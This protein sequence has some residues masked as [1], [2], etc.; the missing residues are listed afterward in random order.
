FKNASWSSIDS[1]GKS[2]YDRFYDAL[3]EVY[4]TTLKSDMRNFGTK[5]ASATLPRDFYNFYVEERAK[6]LDY[7]LRNFLAVWKAQERSL[8]TYE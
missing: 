6:L 4:H 5:D 2:R 7:I 3:M 8:T 1:N